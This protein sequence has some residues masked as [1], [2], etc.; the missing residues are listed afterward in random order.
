MCFCQKKNNPAKEKYKEL[1]AFV[2]N[3]TIP[4]LEGTI[5]PLKMETITIKD[6]LVGIEAITSEL[7][8]FIVESVS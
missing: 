3:K 4:K 1:L 7:K 5:M 2:T 8:D 6:A